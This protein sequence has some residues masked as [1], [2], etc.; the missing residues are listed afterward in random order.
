MADPVSSRDVAARAGVSVATVSNVLNRPEVVTPQTRARVLAAMDALGFVRNE[1]ARQLRAGRSRTIGLV[2]FNVAN[3]VFTEVARGVQDAANLAGASVI[4]CN[5]DGRDTYLERHLT[6]LA[7][8]RVQGILVTTIRAAQPCVDAIRQHGTPVVILG[9]KAPTPDQCSV[10]IDDVAGAGLAASHLLDSG[11]ERLA[12]VG[13]P[14]QARQV[15][16]RARGVRRAMG[17][18]HE[19]LLRLIDVPA[20]D[21]AG[22]QQAGRQIAQLPASERPTGVCCANDLLALGVLQALTEAGLRV[23][24][25]VA[26]VGFDDIEFASAAAIPL[27]SVRQPRYQL[28]R[29]G[30]ELLFEEASGRPHRHQQLI[31]DA[32]LVVRQSSLHRRRRRPGDREPA[33]S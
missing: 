7:E 4:L 16:D 30:A 15:A 18:E 23:P 9:Q 31:L 8:Q 33:A 27:S 13:S 24:Q 12:F 29:R 20:L 22:G 17:K 1:S 25:Q 10:S 11:H 28:G 19:R 2:I 26:L 5:A 21:V 14:A 6:L 32:E 3:P